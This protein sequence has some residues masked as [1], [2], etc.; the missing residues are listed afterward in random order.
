MRYRERHAA[1]LAQGSAT[2]RGRGWTGKD[3]ARLTESE[4]QALHGS[5]Y[6]AS[7]EDETQHAL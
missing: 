2:G 1:A 4:V 6:E 5:H 3:G 7:Q